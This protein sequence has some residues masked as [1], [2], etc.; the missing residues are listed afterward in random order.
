MARSVSRPP[1]R[2]RRLLI[3]VCL[4]ALLPLAAPAP[5]SAAPALPPGFR[6]VD[7][8]SGQPQF[9]LT[10]F[11]FT[12]DGGLVT[13]GKDGTF[14]FLPP[15][16]RTPRR[17]GKAPD[18]RALVDHGMLGLA[19]APDYARSGN[20]YIT[21]D[22]WNAA[23]NGGWGMVEVWKLNNP[24]N[25]T[26]VSYVRTVLDGSK[27]S[28]LPQRSDVHAIDDVVVAADGN[29][30]I[31]VGD[32]TPN[33]GSPDSLR[34][35]DW[36]LPYG[37]V[38]RIRPDGTGA[39]G[40]PR[41]DAAAPN[42]WRSRVFAVGFRNPFRATIRPRTGAV[43]VG[44]VGL[45]RDEEINVVRPGANY[46]WSCYEGPGRSHLAAHPTC[47]ALYANPG[48]TRNPLWSY[49]LAGVGKSVTG[50]M[51]YTGTAYPEQYRG[52]Y[53]F[54]DYS[55]Q[56]LWTLRANGADALERAPERAGFG[57]AVGGPVS[58][59]E[60]P[61]GDVAYA[62]I[63]NGSVRRLV[64]GSGNR[65]PTASFTAAADPATRTVTFD[66]SSSSDLD[67]DPLT[68]RWSFG[69][70]T[71]GTGMTV[72]KTYPDKAARTVVLTVT[73]ALGAADR[74]ERVVRPGNASPVITLS[75]PPSTARFAVNE[76][77]PL[78]AT[79]RDPEDGA[80]QV[81]W[82]SVLQHC[83]SGGACHAHAGDEA[84]GPSF[85]PTFPDHGADVHVEITATATD[86]VG[87]EA[88]A[89]YVARPKLRML[90]VVSRAPVT[91]NGVYAT[92]ARVP[93][94]VGSANTVVAP[95]GGY[96]TFLSW[97]DGGPRERSVRMPDTDLTLT[98]TFDT[99]IERR[100]RQLPWVGSATGPDVAVG[101][102]YSR[103]YRNATMYWSPG[104]GAKEVHGS[105][106]DKYLEMGG[107]ARFGFPLTDELVAAGRGRYS[108]FT[109]GRIYWSERT[110]AHAV[111][112]EILA[113]YRALGGASGLLG[114][115]TTDEIA[116][117]GG[118]ATHFENGHIYWSP[119][120][121]AKELHGNILLAYLRIGGPE[122]YGLPINDESATP[123]GRGRYNHFTSNGSIY[124]TPQTGAHPVYGSIR[125]RWAELGWETSC[126]GYPTSEE[127]AVP[128]GR[129]S[130][131]EGGTI[132]FTASTGRTVARC[133]GRGV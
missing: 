84:T 72:R 81:R 77:V 87:A 59:G 121:G 35:M 54:G 119:T 115:P 80:R 110:G 64:H 94:V 39:P 33:N 98:A 82:R 131:F 32:D 27:D 26:S 101:S 111:Y 109:G 4:A 92:G 76:A 1:S 108:A 126:L 103:T 66:A 75:A 106:L 13:S 20:V 37:K 36:N 117:A 123:D 47:Q 12:S 2:T 48:A 14:T 17:I 128:G 90:T 7:Y 67:G 70:G 23:R 15:G 49:Q 31:T 122:K 74:A 25:P 30:F 5:A 118:R 19:P 63:L 8:P 95:D 127:Y 55:L 96:W 114:F 124:W 62:D 132:T 89:S 130:N 51:F 58:F 107:P 88:V 34:A 85:A 52:A 83:P 53:F 45:G 133:G 21:F 86:S 99:A 61:S 112:G 22:R 69:D 16:T 29:L 105:I 116:V 56:K 93:A 71:T 41:Y 44:D 129:R 10:D 97:S 57:S 113:K 18:V 6:L 79:A 50:G 125:Q 65:P 60:G 102:G 40:N 24:L 42:A 104:A 38:L 68:Y 120:T 78:T 11:F 100:V 91:V 46:G 9:N 28:Q 3:G 73:D 43:Y